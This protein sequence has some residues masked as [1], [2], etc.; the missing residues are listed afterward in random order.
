M[1]AWIDILRPIG[2]VAAVSEVSLESL[3]YCGLTGIIL[4]LDNTI[5]P[6]GSIQIPAEILEWLL[7]AKQ[8]G[9][10]LCLV[11]NNRGPRLP[12]VAQKIGIPF[13]PSANKPGLRAFRQALQIMGIPREQVAVIGDQVFT[14]VLGGNRMGL[15][16]ILV[17]P[18]T[19]REFIGT[20]CIRV[21]ERAFMQFLEYRCIPLARNGETI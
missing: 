19:P 12:A 17:T 15:H 7:E 1:A 8:F 10:R 13:I 21:V 16:T 9:F 18:L 5:T 14:D 3:E 20:R 4:D 2:Q 6:W 11:S